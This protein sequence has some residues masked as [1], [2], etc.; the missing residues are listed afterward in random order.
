MTKLDREKFYKDLLERVFEIEPIRENFIRKNAYSES[1]TEDSY[2]YCR[3]NKGYTAT[4]WF[5]RFQVSTWVVYDRMSKGVDLFNLLA[6]LFRDNK[7]QTEKLREL[8]QLTARVKAEDAYPISLSRN[9]TVISMFLKE[10]D[11]F[12]D[13]SLE[14]RDFE[15]IGL[16]LNQKKKLF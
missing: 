7:K 5:G 15:E 13:K 2:N 6:F 1:L 14:K 8:A 3:K 12:M 11:A 9:A 16:F 4:F 10:I